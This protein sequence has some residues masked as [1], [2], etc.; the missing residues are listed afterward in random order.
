MNIGRLDR[1]VTL[2]QPA[3]VPQNQFGEP[4]PAGFTD[5][6]TVAAGVEYKPGGEA[7]AADQ[8]TATQR[9]VFTLRFRAD[10]RPT[11]QL[12]YEGKTFQITDVAEIG[13]R[14]GLTLT[15]Y[16]HG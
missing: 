3:A 15:C 10:V 4:A 1:Q 12:G 2:Q 5:M 11:W 14:R 9:V 13:R 6:A 7:V 16:S 8:N